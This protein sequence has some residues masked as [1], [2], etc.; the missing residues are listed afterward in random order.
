M[1][2]VSLCFNQTAAPCSMQAGA[3][4][5]TKA[6]KDNSRTDKPSSYNGFLLSVG[7]TTPAALASQL[8]TL[9]DYCPIPDLIT[10]QHYAQ[11]LSSLEQ[12]KLTVYEGQSIEW[13]EHSSQSLKPLQQKQI[14]EELAEVAEQGRSL[15][16]NIDD[17]LSQA[18]ELK[19]ACNERLNRPFTL[20]NTDIDKRILN[21]GSA[22]ALARQV[23]Q[24]GDDSQYWAYCLF[25]GELREL[26]Q[27]KEAL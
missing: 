26:N 2:N 8:E 22:D 27:I 1:H 15:I 6:L 23:E 5:L 13:R 17:A 14:A 16:T 11:S 20:R 9:N 7:A 18:I 10:C 25:V 3:V 21:A 4:L 12:D 19:A 24:L